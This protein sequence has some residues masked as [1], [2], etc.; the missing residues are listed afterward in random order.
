MCKSYIYVYV[1]TNYQFNYFTFFR[2]L[3]TLSLSLM[4]LQSS[5]MKLINCQYNSICNVYHMY[6][7][8]QVGNLYTSKYH[9]SVCHKSHNIMYRQNVH[10]HDLV[11][12]MDNCITITPGILNSS[13]IISEHIYIYGYGFIHQRLCCML[14]LHRLYSAI[15]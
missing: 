1:L 5:H 9:C 13:Y 8:I 3:H 14:V 2:S 6:Y 10:V 7:A 12:L 4:K 15:Y 11:H